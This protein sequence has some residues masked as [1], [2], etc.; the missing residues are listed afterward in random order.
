MINE[1]SEN[2]GAAARP[3][4][5][6]RRVVRAVPGMVVIGAAA[7]AAAEADAAHAADSP[8]VESMIRAR[9]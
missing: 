7:A 4:R 1:S 2:I 8:R 3:M 9:C 5:V 6:E